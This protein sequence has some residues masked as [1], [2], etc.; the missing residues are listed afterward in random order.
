VPKSPKFKSVTLAV[1]THAL[2]EQAA[3][4][5]RKELLI[6]VSLN[7]AVHRLVSRYLRGR[8]DE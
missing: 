2:L 8:K 1:E 5:M 4:K 3:E 6:S 7:D